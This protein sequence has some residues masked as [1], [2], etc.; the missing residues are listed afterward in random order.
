MAIRL[1]NLANLLS[2]TGRNED[3]EPLYR[4][5]L[6]I[7]EKSLGSNHPD[8]A[9]GLYNLGILLH[10]TGREKEGIELLL[11]AYQIYVKSLGPD[12]PSTQLTYK[13]LLSRGQPPET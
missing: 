3:A 6:S 8:V 2:D 1:S 4:Q 5:A 12:H 7:D 9:A 11:R 10:E 13:S